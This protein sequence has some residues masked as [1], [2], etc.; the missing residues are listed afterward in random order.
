MAKGDESLLD[1]IRVGTSAG[2]AKPKAIIAV[3]DD[4]SEIRSGQV[5]APDGFTYWLLKFDGIEVGNVSDNPLGIGRIEYAYHK[6]ALDCGIEMTECRMYEEGQH[7]HF[8]TKRFDRTNAGDKLHTQTLCAIA[9]FDRDDRHSYEQAFQVMRR[10]N[11]PYPDMEQ[12]Y[13]RMVFNIIARNHDDHTKNHS[14]VLAPGGEWRLAPAYDL[15][16]AYSSAG[17]WT[18]Q[19]Q[20][21]A[22]NK[23]DDFTR[24]DLLT[25][26]RNMGIKNA[27][28]IVDQVI[29]VVSNWNNYAS[30]AGVKEVHKKQ[31]GKNLRIMI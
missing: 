17:R 4:M 11:L 19:H 27:L 5:I 12:F 24:E 22:N 1:I 2:G 3:N 30:E 31:I 26:A 21:S 20:L 25:V 6:M 15:C 14:F 8:M 13:R 10:M 29:A 16:Y 23:R 9:H 7:A 18:N 28:P